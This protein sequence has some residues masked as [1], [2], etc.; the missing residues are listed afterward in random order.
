MLRTC[1]AT[2]WMIA[3]LYAPIVGGQ[4]ERLGDFQLSLSDEVGRVIQRCR[5]GVVVFQGLGRAEV[6][7]TLPRRNGRGEPV[8]PLTFHE[9][10]S[11]DES[12]RL[13]SVVQSAALY[14][15]GH[16]G[17][18][19]SAVDGPYE[20]LRMNSSGGAVLLVTSGKPTFVQNPARRELLAQLRAIKK[21]LVDQAL[22]NRK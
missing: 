6:Y 12:T 15:G 2:L 5:L 8:F 11:L 13:V 3:L 18:D 1:A 16:V 17:T 7:C 14:D 10:L 9:Q 21:R 4:T 22:A 19:P 20:P